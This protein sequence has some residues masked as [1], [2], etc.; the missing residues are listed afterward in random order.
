VKKVGCVCALWCVLASCGGKP[1]PPAVKTAAADPPTID[2][3]RVV[4]QPVDVTLSMPGELE[5]YE[6]VAIYPKVTAFVK[7]VRVDRGSQVHAGELL[8]QLEAPELAAQRSEGQSKV[9]ATEAQLASMR[10]KAD[11]DAST[12]D[13]L[14]GAAATP[15]VV[16]G[17]DVIVAEKT[18]EADRSQIAAAAQNVESARQALRSTVDIEGYLRVTAPF[19]GVVTERN[20]HPGALVGPNSGSAST[21]PMLRL[22]QNSRLRLVV[23]VPQ[24]YVSGITKGTTVTFSVSGYPAQKFSGTIARLAQAVDVKTR[25]M[26]VELDVTNRDGRLATGTFCEVQWPV[27]R[28]GPSLF[29]PSGSVAT[30]TDRTFL[31]RVR[32]GL[33]EWVTVSTGLTSGGLVEVFGDVGVGDTIAARGTD[34]IRAGSEVRTREAKPVTRRHE[35]ETNADRIAA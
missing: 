5:A 1:A 17:N 21:L 3:V 8:A 15:G 19:D 34:E 29:V 11:A 23:P 33:T 30:T 24:A 28:P 13:K 35:N 25:T 10:A 6:A 27:R 22:V 12:L 16:A 7:T 18:V 31:V 26:A 20:V 32:N 9:Q 14:K 2:V 4:E